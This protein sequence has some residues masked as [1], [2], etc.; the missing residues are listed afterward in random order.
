MEDYWDIVGRIE[1]K[2]CFNCEMYM[3]HEGKRVCAATY[4][5]Q[6][7][8]KNGYCEAWECDFGLFQKLCSKPKQ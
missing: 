5:G 2:G 7:V 8:D 6:E 3:R 1:K 4:Y